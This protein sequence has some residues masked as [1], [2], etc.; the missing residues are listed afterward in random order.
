MSVSIFILLQVYT[1]DRLWNNGVHFCFVCQ[2]LVSLE[3]IP[4]TMASGDDGVPTFKVR[5]KIITDLTV[6]TVTFRAFQWRSTVF[7]MMGTI[8]HFGGHDWV[9]H[10]RV[11]KSDGGRF[12]KC[13]QN[14]FCRQASNFKNF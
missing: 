14:K 8:W 6:S 13:S 11:R 4:D 1:T 7:A 9:T 10:F 3:S 5:G 12:E 2:L